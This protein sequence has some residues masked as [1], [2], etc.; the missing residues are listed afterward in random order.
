MDFK[1]GDR[2]IIVD[3]PNPYKIWVIAAFDV[4]GYLVRDPEQEIAITGLWFV[5][6]DDLRLVK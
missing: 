4:D 3:A 2:V 1:V 5:D 6:P